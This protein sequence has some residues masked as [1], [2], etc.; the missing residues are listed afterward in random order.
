MPINLRFGER[1]VPC[2]DWPRDNITPCGMP[3]TVPASPQ[4]QEEREGQP[5]DLLGVGGKRAWA[6]SR[7]ARGHLSHIS[8]VLP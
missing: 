7:A 5:A 8:S 6:G 3:G 2:S 4:T 1:A